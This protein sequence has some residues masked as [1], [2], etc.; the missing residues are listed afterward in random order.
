MQYNQLTATYKFTHGEM[1]HDGYFLYGNGLPLAWIGINDY[2]TEG[3][4]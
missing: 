2:V 4:K 3:V 1:V